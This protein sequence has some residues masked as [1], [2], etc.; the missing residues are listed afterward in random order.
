MAKGGVATYIHRLPVS[1]SFTCHAGRGIWGF[2][3]W[4]APM[5]VRFDGSTVTGSLDGEITIRLRRGPIPVPARPLT[6]ACY[7]NDEAGS[8]LRTEW[9]TNNRSTRLR[10]GRGAAQVTVTGDGPFA[11]D[12]R[13]LGFPRKPVLSMVAAEMRA[14]FGAPTPL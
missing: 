1:Q 2:P 10:F 12:L 11:Q 13:T 9:V 5:S 6:M 3:K 14:T 7:S 4:V 8:L